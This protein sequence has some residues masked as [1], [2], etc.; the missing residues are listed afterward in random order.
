MDIMSIRSDLLGVDHRSQPKIV[1]AEDSISHV[2]VMS[3]NFEMLGISKN[4]DW[5]ANG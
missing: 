4:I 1:I 2:Q 3:A 5:C